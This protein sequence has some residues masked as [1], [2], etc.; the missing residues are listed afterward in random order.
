MSRKFTDLSKD[1]IKFIVNEIFSPE[2]ITNIKTHKRDDEI[3]CT[4]YTEWESTDDDG[5]TVVDLIPDEIELR[6][7]FDYNSYA[8]HAQF[9]L[10]VNDF[11]KLKS[12]CYAKGI[13]GKSIE[14]LTNNPYIDQ[15]W[16]R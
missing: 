14:W 4:I 1:E 6:N 16:K 9:S 13:Y 12:F 11:N 15:K 5:K 2:K 10:S 8:L 7:P 3:T